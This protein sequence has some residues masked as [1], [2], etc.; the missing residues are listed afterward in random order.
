VFERGF[1]T[2]ARLRSRGLSVVPRD[3]E[4]QLLEQLDLD[5]DI[6]VLLVLLLESMRGLLR[7]AR[8]YAGN[9]KLLTT[10]MSWTSLGIV[11]GD[12]VFAQA[13]SANHRILM[14][15]LEELDLSAVLNPSQILVGLS[16]LE[17]LS[18]RITATMQEHVNYLLERKA[19]AI[20]IVPRYELQLGSHVTIANGV[21]TSNDHAFFSSLKSIIPRSIKTSGTLP[22]SK[23]SP[24][25]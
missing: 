13:F 20:M 18:V 11:R 5:G 17:S 9:F 8:F 15:K 23:G 16:N 4:W 6:G 21:A 2:I 25:L 14:P 19:R 22:A 10:P 1:P 12:H 7:V 3:R 24:A